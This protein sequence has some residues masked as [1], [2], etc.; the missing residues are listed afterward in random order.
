[1]FSFWSVCGETFFI[2][3][4]FS[5]TKKNSAL[6]TKACQ[7]IFVIRVSKSKKWNRRFWLVQLKVYHFIFCIVHDFYRFSSWRVKIGRQKFV[8]SSCRVLSGRAIFDQVILVEIRP[9]N[10][11]RPHEEPITW[12]FSTRINWA[13]IKS[14]WSRVH[15]SKIILESSLSGPSNWYSININWPNDNL[16]SSLISRFEDSSKT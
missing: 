13:L 10:N 5:P 14:E 4:W 9:S 1:M 3:C 8:L 6:N 16:W 11:C 12:P 15:L 2:C 7:T